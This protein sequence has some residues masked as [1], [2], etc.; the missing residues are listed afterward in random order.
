[1]PNFPRPWIEKK[2]ATFDST[3][4]Q[5][6]AWVKKQLDVLDARKAADEKHIKENK[7]ILDAL[8]GLP[9]LG[10]VAVLLSRAKSNSLEVS[11]DYIDTIVNVHKI[12]QYPEKPQ[13]ALPAA[14]T[15]PYDTGDIELE[16]YTVSQYEK[17]NK[18]EI[19]PEE[20][21]QRTSNKALE[22]NV[23]KSNGVYSPLTAQE[24]ESARQVEVKRFEGTEAQKRDQ[25][26][27][28][29]NKLVKK[30]NNGEI[31][32][33][34]FAVHPD[35]IARDD[36]ETQ[37]QSRV[38]ERQIQE[39]QKRQNLKQQ[40]IDT[41][42]QRQRGLTEAEV[43]RN[44]ALFGP[45]W[46]R[47]GETKKLPGAQDLKPFESPWS[48]E[49]KT[50]EQWNSEIAKSK[51]DKIA[52]DKRW[53][54][55]KQN[56][57]DIEARIKKIDDDKRADQFKARQ[58]YTERQIEEETKRLGIS[59]Q[60]LLN[61]DQMAQD[62]QY[63]REDAQ[64]LV[65][66]LQGDLQEE[67]R[68][69][70]AEIMAKRSQFQSEQYAIYKK[71]VEVTKELKAFNEYGERLRKG[72]IYQPQNLTDF[73]NHLVQTRQKQRASE[74][75][76]GQG[77][78]Y[79]LFGNGNVF[80]N[81]DTID[82]N[83]ELG[84]RLAKNQDTST[85]GGGKAAVD[86]YYRN[87]DAEKL[88]KELAKNSKP[89]NTTS[90]GAGTYAVNEY[91][92]N[93]EAKREAERL[94]P[95][96]KAARGKGIPEVQEYYQ[97]QDAAREER[98]GQ[99]DE[100]RRIEKDKRNGAGFKEIDRPIKTTNSDVSFDQPGQLAPIKRNGNQSNTRKLLNADNYDGQTIDISPNN[101]PVNGKPQRRN[102]NVVASDT[103]R[104]RRAI[105]GGDS[106]ANIPKSSPFNLQQPRN[107]K[108]AS[109]QDILGIVNDGL[110]YEGARK[111]LED[112]EKWKNNLAYKNGMTRGQLDAIEQAY[113]PRKNV[114]SPFDWISDKF[115]LPKATKGLGWEEGY[116]WRTD[117]LGLEQM[118]R[119]AKK[120][121]SP[122]RYRAQFGKEDNGQGRDKSP[123]GP[124]P[125][126]PDAANPIMNRPF[127]D[128]L[129]RPVNGAKDFLEKSKEKLFP[130]PFKHWTNP[131]SGMTPDEAEAER[132]RKEPWLHPHYFP[133]V[134]P[135]YTPIENAIPA[136]LPAPDK[137]PD[138]N[139]GKRPIKW[140]VTWR[141]T[142]SF[143]LARGR[144]SYEYYFDVTSKPE[145]L[146]IDLEPQ[147]TAFGPSNGTSRWIALFVNGAEVSR[148]GNGDTDK[149]GKWEV[150]GMSLDEPIPV[151]FEPIP[152]YQPVIV[153]PPNPNPNPNSNPNP[154]PLPNE[155]P[156]RNKKKSF[157]KPTQDNL[158][159]PKGPQKIP[160]KTPKPLDENTPP[161]PKPDPQ[162]KPAPKDPQEPSRNPYLT[163]KP[164]PFPKPPPKDKPKKPPKERDREDQTP[165]NNTPPPKISRSWYEFTIPTPDLFPEPIPTPDYPQEDPDMPCRYATDTQIPTP[166]QYFDKL[167][168]TRKVQTFMIHEGLDEAIAF[169]AGQIADAKE[170]THKISSALEADLYYQPTGKPMVPQVQ[171]EVMGTAMFGGA[172]VMTAKSIPM[173]MNAW[174]SLNH[175]FSGH[176][177]LG[178]SDFPADM[179][180]PGG[181]KTKHTTALGF[182]HW[183]FNQMT[184]LVGMPAKH[185][186]VDKD[187]VSTSQS[188]KNQSDAIENIHS[189]NLGFEQDLSAMEKMLFKIS[190]ALEMI[191]QVTIQNQ[192]DIEVLVKESGAKT[193]Q[194]MRDRPGVFTH[195]KDDKNE[196]FFDRMMN[197]A[198]SV[199]V[200]RQ[201]DD[202]ID[203][204]QL[205]QKTNMEAQIAAMSNKFEFDKTSPKLPIVDRPK[206]NPKKQQEDEWRRYVK[207]SE[208]PGTVRQS[209]GI[210]VPEF[211]EIKL[212][213]DKEIPEPETEPTKLLGS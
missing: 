2:S 160:N 97:R 64:K 105:G 113:T 185:N 35:K 52:S 187:G 102:Q 152:D 204:K 29:Y 195:G 144:G 186:I 161:K 213:V 169:L 73:D 62:R 149:N 181:A 139:A 86:E 111:A 137:P 84:K 173:E 54:Q 98:I 36:F 116:D 91:Y 157:D 196:S 191:T 129:D 132:Y 117:P 23:N 209:P 58:Q 3:Q 25:L 107:L 78:Q 67:Q 74:A 106:P 83:S 22:I 126:N 178:K 89:I 156:K 188:F 108:R 148:N 125:T 16:R 201:W 76:K 199:M 207:T 100:A 79:D 20:F 92:Q 164:T 131:Y 85:I 123:M 44:K 75:V 60:E 32:S 134:D 31:S 1:M 71:S 192:A 6:S 4:F 18:N 80:G 172:G 190:Q 109:G 176:H 200:V 72:E 198:K 203:A 180:K 68:K 101:K 120:G 50:F 42:I 158:P 61:M 39:E 127:G 19:T 49:G 183:C 205:A 124:W 34:E 151:L 17:L 12:Y 87:L 94:N 37:R 128:G 153:T 202:K 112:Y 69:I 82:P 5:H 47:D 118:V 24:F 174:A 110:Q 163:P 30:L 165:R 41:E 8:T 170:E 154:K 130:D 155:P 43:A 146:L 103:G 184:N 179:M 53:E 10:S 197:K 193:K 40:A 90:P 57:K 171:A 121:I 189:Q 63:A 159:K 211:K 177:Q 7:P 114:W 119:A 99:W 81:P 33:G 46:E 122:R 66:K 27:K 142:H 95:K 48:K 175:M 141:L 96:P 168:K 55:T 11:T 166:I 14:K 138:P 167:S 93:L 206:Q 38:N 21:R 26:A 136:A 13:L 194:V 145:A 59:R 15:Y 77:F 133:P 51:S 56:N 162:K 135:D 28:N 143:P 88:K 140:K 70:D 147:P 182:N 9:V 210:P 65:R 104:E 115:N 212:G 208:K 45:W 150:F